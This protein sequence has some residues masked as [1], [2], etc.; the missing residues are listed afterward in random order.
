MKARKS[1]TTESAPPSAPTTAGA[2][3]S[4]IAF[5][6]L[7]AALAHEVRNP[8]NSMAIQV[9]LLESRCQR[10]PS[11]EPALKDAA[12]R[13]LGVL[14]KE[15]ARVDGL[16]DGYLRNVLAPEPPREEV[17][18]AEL[19][20]AAI[21]RAAAG[22]K[23]GL[24]IDVEGPPPRGRWRLDR[25]AVDLALDELLA[26][27]IEASPRAGA[28]R[29]RAFEDDD[30]SGV[31]EIVD[32]GDGIA[33]EVLP[34]V[35]R[36]GFTTRRGHRGLGLTIAKQAIKGLGGSLLLRSDGKGKGAVARLE[37]PLDEPDADPA[38]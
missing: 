5:G 10:S 20:A 2:T 30:G 16:L 1:A 18:V 31:I 35:F 14:R 26:N 22:Q 33:P 12:S 9:E 28:I 4:P 17:A 37:L 7:A 15:I 23:R 11:I 25:P 38:G 24:R 8:L 36:L 29:L 32:A 6:H 13:S 3:L 21:D 34:D 27:A 19:L